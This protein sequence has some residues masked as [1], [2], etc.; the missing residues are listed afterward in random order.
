MEKVVVTFGI[1]QKMVGDSG[2]SIINS[3]FT[4]LAKE[5]GITHA[6]GTAFSPWTNGKVEI[7]KKHLVRYFRSFLRNSE[8]NWVDHASKF[9]FAHNTTAI[10]STSMTP[11]EKV[12]ELKPQIPLSLKLGLLRNLDLACVDTMLTELK[13]PRTEPLLASYCL[14]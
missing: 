1:P 14:Q 8:R 4:N 9:A 3:D 2:S 6:P 11:Y 10:Y 12:F 7:Q 5:L 13:V